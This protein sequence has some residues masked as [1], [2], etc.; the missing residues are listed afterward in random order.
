MDYEKMFKE[1]VAKVDSG[2]VL[3][4]MVRDKEVESDFSNDYI[5]GVLGAYVSIEKKIYELYKENGKK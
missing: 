1:L 5:S 4:S 2:Y 3:A